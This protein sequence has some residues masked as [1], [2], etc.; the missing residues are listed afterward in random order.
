MSYQEINSRTDEL[1]DSVQNVASAYHPHR[2][3]HRPN[4]A[5]WYRWLI[6]NDLTSTIAGV[7]SLS[8]ASELGMSIQAQKLIVRQK[9]VELLRSVPKYVV[10]RFEKP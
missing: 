4:G 6:Y 9:T 1:T 7:V 5:D 3:D 10:F 2:A 8:E